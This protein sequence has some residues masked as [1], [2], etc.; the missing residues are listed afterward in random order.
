MNRYSYVCI[1]HDGQET[2]GFLEAVN[3]E[4]A[5]IKLMEQGLKIIRVDHCSS[6]TSST[7]EE[8]SVAGEPLEIIDFQSNHLSEYGKAAWNTE[9]EFID[10]VARD[11]E[12]QI[13]GI[14]LSASLRTLAEE[15]PSKKLTREL[16]KIAEDLEHGKTPEDSFEQ[17]LKNVPQNLESLIRAGAQTGKLESIIEDYIESQRLMAQTRHRILISVFYTS[18]LVFGS[19]LLFYFLLVTVVSN[20]K[21]I[22]L[23]FGTELP[24]ITI[25]AFSISDFFSQFGFPIVAYPIV[26]ALGFWFS[27]DLLKLQATRRRLLNLIPIFGSILNYTSIAQFC[28]MLASIIEANIKLPKA[29]ELAA[30]STRDPNLIAGCQILKKRMAD[31]SNLTQA[32]SEIPNFNKSFAHLFRWQDQPEIFIDSLR[33]SS[34]IFQAKANMKTG[35]LVFA[36]KPLVLA[37]VMLTIGM[38][39][40]A[41][42]MPLIKLL[43]DLS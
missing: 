34:N 7:I 19:F 26:F 2:R 36:L 16:Q 32:T 27:F 3:D 29:I 18:V 14:P 23:D 11:S 12:F 37:G 30:D 28:R 43:N 24:G 39:I 9:P 25:L 17:H 21:S 33:A 8:T 22:F 5:R 10:L 31:G 6:D 15:T 1:N 40:F 42:V 20:F 41:L 35:S 38:L 4:S 13:Y